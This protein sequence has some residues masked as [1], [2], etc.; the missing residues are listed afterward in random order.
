MAIFHSEDK[1]PRSRME[2]LSRTT[3]G[4]QLESQREF[5]MALRTGSPLAHKA[6]HYGIMYLYGNQAGGGVLCRLLGLWCWRGLSSKK[7]EPF[8]RFIIGQVG[9]VLVNVV[10]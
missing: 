10:C 8:V 6:S 7:E 2:R 5:R 1:S 3:C 9:I 4:T